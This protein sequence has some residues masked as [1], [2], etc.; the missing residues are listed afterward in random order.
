M[1]LYLN[2]SISSALLELL[3]EL[4][5]S[6]T[7]VPY[8]AQDLGDHYPVAIGP[9]MTPTQGIERECLCTLVLLRQRK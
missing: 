5:V 6:R 1:Y 3:L 9:T 7:G 4:Q 2:A 8:A